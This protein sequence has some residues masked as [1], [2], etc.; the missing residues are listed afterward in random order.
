MAKQ[1]PIRSA[2]EV[3]SLIDAQS[4]VTVLGEANSAYN[5]EIN[6]LLKKEVLASLQPDLFLSAHASFFNFAAKR[7]LAISEGVKAFV[8]PQG[9]ASANNAKRAAFE[10]VIAK[11]GQQ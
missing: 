10:A 4:D 2:A 7:E 8:D 6:Y 3:S 1:P 5:A 11:E 9:Y